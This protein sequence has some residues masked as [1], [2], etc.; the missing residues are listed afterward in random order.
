MV[1][2]AELPLVTA[3]ASEPVTVQV[4]AGCDAPVTEA[5]TDKVWPT[6]RLAG[7]KGLVIETVTPESGVS[8]KIVT[9]AETELSLSA[10]LVAVMVTVAG[11]GTDTGA[12]YRPIL[13]IVPTAK[14]PPTTPFTDHV[15]AVFVLFATLAVNWKVCPT[16]NVG[17]AEPKTM[18][19]AVGVVGIVA[20]S[21]TPQPTITISRL[22]LIPKTDALR[23]RPCIFDSAPSRC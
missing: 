22:R 13:D 4:R 14:F 10:L 3:P 9:R 17:G 8:S 19:T 12:V 6:V 5:V 21:P 1:P 18:V 16:V 7:L 20:D 2:M 11:V 15:A 23:P